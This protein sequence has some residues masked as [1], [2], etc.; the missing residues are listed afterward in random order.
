[1]NATSV[2]F[3]FL[4]EG[5]YIDLNWLG[6]FVKVIVEGV[7]IVGVGV[8][9]FTLILKAI[10]TPFDVYQRFKMRKQTLMMRERKEEMERLQ[11][12]YRN[13]SKM[14]N[15]KMM[16]IQKKNGAGMLGACLPM[17]ISIVILFVAVA[18]F[19]SYSQYANLE[20]YEGM[21]HAY[22]AA[23]MEYTVDGSVN[24]QE[25]RLDREG[26]AD[27]GRPV[28]DWDY[29]EPHV[30][31]DITYTVTVSG[32]ATRMEVRSA[33]E[34]AYIYYSYSLDDTTVTREY[35]IDVD[36]MYYNQQDAALKAALDEY[37]AAGESVGDACRSYFEELGAEA[38][39]N[40][41]RSENSPSFL[42]IKNVWYPDVS[43]AHPIQEYSAFTQSF[44]DG[45]R[46]DAWGEEERSITEVFSQSEYDLLT[47]HLQEEKETPN[48]Y[49][50]MIV[51]TIGLMVLSQFIAMKSSKESNQY[52]TVDGQGNRMQK[53]MLIIM[54]LIYAITGFMWT[55]AF[56]IYI[57]VSSIISI[58]VTLISNLVLGRI[59]NKRE[60][61][62]IRA[63]YT[64]TYDWME[65]NKEEKKNK[66]KKGGK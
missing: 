52:S 34:D 31:G 11:Q 42:W 57:A 38:A 30:I 17:I 24:G 65:K 62:A 8:I 14:Y 37:V 50:I 59:F 66:N 7:G 64:R 35:R 27:D 18:A 2:I 58:L 49:Y 54:P 41:F 22:N 53:M 5:F 60:E 36:K 39:A 3:Q 12:Q 29:S 26:S 46:M 48:G 15:Q 61:E 19:Q 51:L 32:S 45:I 63:K 10:T 16:E 9:V 21:A 33:R 4:Q 28:I 20:M 47:A 1:M 44:S 6:Q 25:Y 40:H 55:A 23:V 43:Y 56:S 13:D